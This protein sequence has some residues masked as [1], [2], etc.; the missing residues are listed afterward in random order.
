[1]NKIIVSKNKI[2]DK[3]IDNNT[4]IYLDKDT[5]IYYYDS[6]VN[7]TFVVMKSILISEYIE[8]STIDN[9]YEIRDDLVFNRF[10]LDSEIVSSLDMVVSNKKVSY[11][12]SCINLNDH[13]Y[14]LNINHLAFS[15]SSYILNHGVNFFNKKLDFLVNTLVDSSSYG[16]MSNQ[17]SKILL[18]GDN[19]SVIKPNLLINN[20]DVEVNHSAY[21]GSF[22]DSDLFYLMSRGLGI[23]DA[24]KILTKAFIFSGMNLSFD[25]R[26]LIL[27][28]IEKYWR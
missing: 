12:Y 13:C 22:K 9:K 5:E 24:R 19:H 21:I 11:Y 28:N 26:R 8:H 16:V 2:L 1:M 14:V 27:E 4:V 3:V 6:C 23:Y 15:T 17:D 25:I 20:N 10:A 7:L 18:L